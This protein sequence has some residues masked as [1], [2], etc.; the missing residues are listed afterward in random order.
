MLIPLLVLASAGYVGHKEYKKRKAFTPE[1]KALYARAMNSAAD[2]TELR[3]LAASF[4]SVGLHEQ[5]MK[6]MKRASLRE[7]PETVKA[8]RREIFKK[9]MNSQDPDAIEKIA[10]AHEEVGAE[11]AAQALRLQAETLRAVKSA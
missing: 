1:R 4:E 6:L 11:G 8:A 9:A 5:A 2:P 7:A 10:K 3:K